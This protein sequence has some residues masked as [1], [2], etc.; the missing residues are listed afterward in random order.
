M[1]EKMEQRLR[2]LVETNMEG[3]RVTIA[4]EWKSSG[5]KIIG[6][7]CPYVPEEL[8]MAAG[9]LPWRVTGTWRYNVP[10]ASVYRP[11]VTCRFSTHVLEAALNGELSFLD[12]IVSTNRDDD[13]KRLWDIIDNQKVFSYSHIMHLPHM[14]SSL[15]LDAWKRSINKLKASL[16][17]FLGEISDQS[18]AESIEVVN[19]TRAL[20][21]KLYEMRKRQV[22][23]LTGAEYLGLA[24]AAGIMPKGQFNSELGNLLPYI[25][26]R[27]GKVGCKR[28]RIM[29][30]ADLL[31]DPRYLQLVED[32]GAVVAMDDIDVG[33]R[34]VSGQVDT[35]EKDL[36]AALAFRYLITMPQSPR[37]WDWEKQVEQILRWV[38]EYEIDGVVELP[39][40]SSFPIEFRAS[41]LRDCLTGA[42]IRSI[43]ISREYNFANV[44]Q[45]S[46][47]VGAF[48]EMLGND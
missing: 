27:E 46:T 33:S 7:L 21:S 29:V 44:G 30:S 37:M 25:E 5:R 42:G 2:N 38:K 31:D 45:V 11:L 41:F 14:S 16:G 12:G 8:I 18:L 26:Q 23:P 1:D 36:E 34:L 17:D 20:F 24:T 22:P 3:N 35:S 39:S 19:E 32:A 15:G 9:A 10:K 6:M 43:S 28:P 48:I 13:V 40:L 47:R 4:E